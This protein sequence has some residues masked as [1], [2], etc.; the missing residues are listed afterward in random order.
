MQEE[1][2]QGCIGRGLCIPLPRHALKPRALHRTTWR[3]A[4]RHAR[5][6]DTGQDWYLLWPGKM[7]QEAGKSY[8]WPQSKEKAMYPGFVWVD[9]WYFSMSPVDAN[10]D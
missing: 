8:L 4:H 1:T 3:A 2:E 7:R 6:E 9:I 10:E 5:A